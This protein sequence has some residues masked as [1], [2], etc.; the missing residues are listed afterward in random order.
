MRK[1]LNLL[2]GRRARLENELDRELRYHFDRRVDDLRAEGRGDDEAR[3]QAAIEMGGIEQVEEDVRETW[4]WRWLEDAVRDARYAAR[5]LARSPGFTITAVGWRQSTPSK[6]RSC[7]CRS[8]QIGYDI[9]LTPAPLPRACASALP[10]QSTR[11]S[12]SG[13]RTGRR[14]RS[15]WSRSEKIAALAPMPMASDATA[16]A[17]NPGLRARLRAA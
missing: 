6:N 4:T 8:R 3:K 9:R 17:V 13:S 14:R 12:R 5:S 15:T 2:R 7:L 1:I 10:F 16:V 11:T